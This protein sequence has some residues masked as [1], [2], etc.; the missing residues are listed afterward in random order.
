MKIENSNE[1]KLWDLSDSNV[2]IKIKSSIREELFSYL[3]KTNNGFRGLSKKVDVTFGYLFKLKKG[4]YFTSLILLN[5]LLDICPE[6]KKKE[7]MMKI[8]NNIEEIKLGSRSLSIKNPKLPIKFSSILA[9]IAGHLCGDGGIR[10]DYIVYYT[11]SSSELLSQFERDIKETLGEVKSGGFYNTIIKD[12]R[13]VTFP[14]IIGFF[15]TRLFGRQVGDLKHIPKLILD[16]DK[17]SKSLFLNA[18]FDDE[19]NVST[20][21]YTISIKMANKGII[22]KVKEILKEFEIKSGKISK[23]HDKHKTRYKFYISGKMNLIRFKEEI[24]FSHLE[25]RE[26]LSF[27]T[28]KYQRYK[29]EEIKNLAINILKNNKDVTISELARKLNRKPSMRFKEHLF[30]LE[31]EGVIISNIYN[32]LKFYNISN[33]VK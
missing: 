5:K 26:K 2:Y 15:L 24:N 18:L 8:E 10:K 13:T 17:F 29:F 7:F 25:K 32:R 3:T 21:A 1:I 4:F 14:G 33:K 27:L 22:E 20:T 23:T 12:V 11:N 16:S 30:K 31:K 9:R 19:G 28:Q 6:K